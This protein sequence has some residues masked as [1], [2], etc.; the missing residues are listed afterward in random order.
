MKRTILLFL[1]LYLF[2][3]VG[4]A[5]N[6]P[7]ESLGG[8]EKLMY[9]E[10]RIAQM[11]YKIDNY[12]WAADAYQKM[13]ESIEQRY[14]A[15][16]Q[17]A[18]HALKQ[19]LP[20]LMAMSPCYQD[21]AIYYRISGDEKYL[22]LVVEGI[23]DAFQLDDKDGVLFPDKESQN[24]EIW[25][26]LMVRGGVLQAYDLIK[27]HPLMQ[28]YIPTMELRLKEIV[29]ET[30]RYTTYM[31]HAGNTQFWTITMGLG[32]CAMLLDDVETFK[33]A[34]YNDYYGAEAILNSFKDGGV[35]RAE[36][37]RYYYG[38][39]ASC[40]TILFEIAQYNDVADMYSYTSS[41]GT[42]FE[43]VLEGL[44][45]MVTPQ[46]WLPS[47]G[48]MGE[49]A[50]IKDDRPVY[51]ITSI[52][53]GRGKWEVYNRVYDNPK[54]AWAV[55]QSPDRSG[56]SGNFWSYSALVHG[57][58]LEQCQAPVVKSV[59][60]QS[61]GD[62]LLKSIEGEEYWYSDAITVHVRGGETLINHNH[63]DQL[64][65][66][67]NAFGK[68]IYSDWSHDYDYIAP[69]KANNY[70][71]QTPFSPSVLSHNTIA[72]DFSEPTISN[73]LYSEID[74][75]SQGAQSVIA[76]ATPY[77]GVEAKRTICLTGEYV[78][79]IFEVSSDRERN[80]DFILNSFGTVSSCGAGESFEYNT[81]NEEYG[82]QPIDKWAKRERNVWIADGR[83]S[84]VEADNL[85]VT[86][87]DADGVGATA[88]TLCEDATELITAGVPYYINKFSWDVSDGG[89]SMPERKPMVMLRRK[90]ASTTFYTIH[91]PFKEFATQVKLTKSG[92]VLRIESEKFTDTY[93]LLTNEY[94]R[95][96][97]N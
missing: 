4:V 12:Q 44:F 32:V 8:G 52:F 35:S 20:P 11:R 9:G 66:K 23:I 40:L 84:K 91:Y 62:V 60:R 68:G 74:R 54:F 22:P 58:E 65:I 69:R 88:T 2:A 85:V 38:Y 29:G 95:V 37:V 19:S 87:R 18:A 47:S 48:D 92:D 67:L 61:V 27:T 56:D 86:F 33:D 1:S 41:Q 28:P 36:P 49:R 63:R 55:A 59:V 64:H 39:V 78:I 14:Q 71:N 79:D 30:K 34:L 70:A 89:G 94:Q 76:T 42:T 53:D 7:T 10:E 21:M 13:Q 93:N 3:G 73:V 77:E 82:L 15:S 25:L 96:E 24:I 26:W 5:N 43:G 97:S 75:A 90:C 80:Y 17:S 83:K 6:W 50:S 57:V 16:E 46:G 72:V 31:R 81:L 51:D 45:D